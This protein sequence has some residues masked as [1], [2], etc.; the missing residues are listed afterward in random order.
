MNI[1]LTILILKNQQKTIRLEKCILKMNF[2]LNFILYRPGPSPKVGV[3]NQGKISWSTTK[4]RR[5]WKRLELYWH[6]RVN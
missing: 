1:E 2:I 6:F 5:R 4:V 3:K